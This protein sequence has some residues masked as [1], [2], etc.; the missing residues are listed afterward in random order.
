MDFGAEWI[1]KCQKNHCKCSK[2]RWKVTNSRPRAPLS[3][4][5]L[6]VA[7][8]VQASLGTPLSHVAVL[9]E[10]RITETFASVAIQFRYD[11]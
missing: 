5:V 10:Y 6:A 7:K 8:L 11:R 1:P 2:G 9:S 4:A 3:L